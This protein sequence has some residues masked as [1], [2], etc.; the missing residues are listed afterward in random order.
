MN[1]YQKKIWDLQK[2]RLLN[3]EKKDKLQR[4]LG[5]IVEMKK[6]PDLI[7]IIDTNIEF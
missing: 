7:F 5:G 1:N 3:L 4:S 6:L 2:K